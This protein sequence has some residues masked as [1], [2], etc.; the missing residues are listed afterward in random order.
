MIILKRSDFRL[1]YK[2]KVSFYHLPGTQQPNQFRPYTEI[3]SS[4]IPHTQINSI[5]TI[6]KIKSISMLTKNK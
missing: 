2:L 6:T 4:S 5:S 1:A 3:K